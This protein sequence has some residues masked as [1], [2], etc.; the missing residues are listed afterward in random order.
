M[1]TL[2]SPPRRPTHRCSAAAGQGRR[3]DHQSPHL[4][5]RPR[6]RKKLRRPDRRAWLQPRGQKRRDETR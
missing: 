5:G 4:E 1:S 2:K 6:R 3:G